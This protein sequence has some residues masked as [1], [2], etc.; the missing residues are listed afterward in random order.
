MSVVY[1]D[2]PP[3]G[4]VCPTHPEAQAVATC[5]NC[6]QSWCGACLVVLDSRVICVECSRQLPALADP[7]NRVLAGAIDY[8]IPLML[9]LNGPSMLGRIHPLAGFVGIA[10]ALGSGVFMLVNAYSALNGRPT[11]GQSMQRIR[12]LPRVLPRRKLSTRDV[13]ARGAAL[14]AIFLVW[15]FAS[16]ELGEGLVAAN[17][18][19]IVVSRA[20]LIDRVT[21]TQVSSS[22]LP[23]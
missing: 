9:M 20:S 17:V 5:P 16:R 18:I 15:R 21:K 10:L 3:E 1:A 12:V 13:L 8:G 19:A 6:K 22:A 4:L 14:V 11:F 23:S 7:R 2:S